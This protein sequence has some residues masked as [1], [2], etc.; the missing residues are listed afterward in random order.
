MKE[1]DHWIEDVEFFSFFWETED[2]D[3]Y[4]ICSDV[5]FQYQLQTNQSIDVYPKFHAT[6]KKLPSRVY[7]IALLTES[8]MI[9]LSTFLGSEKTADQN[10]IGISN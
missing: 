9:D 10:Q 6:Y 5:L 2:V 3:H 1:L 8:K 4:C 7:V